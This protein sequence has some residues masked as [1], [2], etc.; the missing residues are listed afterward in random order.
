ML[1][2]A[3]GQQSSLGLAEAHQV[4]AV[5]EAAPVPL[6]LLRAVVQQH[7]NLHLPLQSTHHQLNP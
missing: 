2:L 5:Q 6:L 4:G 3:C 7:G 1:L